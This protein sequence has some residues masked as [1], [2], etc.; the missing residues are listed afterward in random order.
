[1]DAGEE[2]DRRVAATRGAGDE[3]GDGLVGR[4]VAGQVLVQAGCSHGSPGR[5]GTRRCRPPWPRPR[6]GWPVTHGRLPA[7]PSSDDASDPPF[8][9]GYAARMSD[10]RRHA[11]GDLLWGTT[12]RLVRRA[13]EAFSGR[14]AVVDGDMVL[15]YEDLAAAVEQAARAFVAAG[16]EPGDRAAIW[17]PNI[18]RVDRRRARPALGRRGARPG[19]HP[20]QGPRGRRHRRPGPGSGCC[21]PSPT[22]STPTTWPCS[23]GRL[24]G[25]GRDRPV[26]DLAAL[27]RI[28][29]LRGDV[30]D[31]CQPWSDFLRSGDEIPVRR[32]SS[33]GPWRS[34]PATC[35]TSSS[36]R[37]RPGAPRGS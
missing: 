21:S 33:P 19:E 37:G 25:P 36:P 14:S 24:G 28:V 18:A 22:S 26:A 30:P 3:G 31:G 34:I 11:C 4:D 29:V 15:S 13:A 32:W 6:A 16:L 12:P 5:R 9:V 27:E 10:R 7:W 1:M 17:A 20:V 8:G 23:E 35:P 2:Q